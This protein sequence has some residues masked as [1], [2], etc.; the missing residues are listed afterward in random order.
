MLKS[1]KKKPC[2]AYDNPANWRT[3]TKATRCSSCNG[4]GSITY[5]NTY[6]GD[7]ETEFVDSQGRWRKGVIKRTGRT[8]TTRTT[9]QACQGS[10]RITVHS[11]TYTGPE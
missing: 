11:E 2:A 4:V 8:Y 9:C 1:V 6:G 10:G 3:S 7:I 5:S